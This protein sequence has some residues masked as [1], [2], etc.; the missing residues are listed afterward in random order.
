LRGRVV[1]GDLQ[2]QREA[3]GET[4]DVRKEKKQKENLFRG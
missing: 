4:T 2:G 3:F 1:G